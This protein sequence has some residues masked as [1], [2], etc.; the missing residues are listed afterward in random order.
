VT[1]PAAPDTTLPS[2][3]G[4]VTGTATNST[5]VSLSWGASTDNVGV[6][7][8]RVFKDGATTALK[9]VTTTS[10]TDAVTAATTH[11]Y[12]V[13]AIDAAGNQSAKTAAVSVT[14]PAAAAADT[15][16]PTVSSRTPAANAFSV[17]V[18]NNITATFS[19]PV[20]G[21]PTTAG[22]S[23]LFTLKNAAG[24]AIAA[25]VVYNATTHVATLDPTANLPADTKYTAT[26][27]GGAS[28]IKDAAGN[29][30]AT[31]TWTFT[32]GPAPTVSART[33]ASGATGVSRTAN[34]TA[35][36]SEAVQGLPGTTAATSTLV[37]LKATATGT[38]VGAVV[39]RNG[40]TNQYI[41]NPGVTLNA[42][43]QYT[44][45]LTGGSTGI[46]D[47]AGN[48]LATTSWSFTTGAV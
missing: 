41:L 20:T 23:A 18:A 12:A 19:E 6:T 4:A 27:T 48:P 30:L 28:G 21:L 2:T 32:T 24:T 42:N 16:A 14:T 33:P 8:Y 37:T 46:R 26:L 17:A 25:T 5:T 47:L 13:A 45:T 35:T 7:G 15:V 9:T 29:P 36:F 40:T 10:T 3:P 44:V 31:T 43:T 11:T 38:A 1:T 39:S 22:T 34:I